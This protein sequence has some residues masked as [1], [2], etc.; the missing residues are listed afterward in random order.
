MPRATRSKSVML[1]AA[2]IACSIAWLAGCQSPR[3]PSAELDPNRAS[4]PQTELGP[5]PDKDMVA[6]VYN[7]RVADISRLA[8]PFTIVLNMPGEKPGSRRREQLEGNLQ[9]IQPDKVSLRIDKVGQTLLV[10]GAGS[11]KYW[12][13]EFGD[14]RTAYVGEIAQATYSKAERL[15]VPVHPLDIVELIG[16]VPLTGNEL[17]AWDRGFLRLTS[18]ARFGSRVLFLDPQ[19][20]EPR[21]VWLRDPRGK[22]AVWAELTRV[23]PVQVEA[24]V[25]SQARMPLRVLA[26][27]P[28]ADT[29]M[30]LSFSQPRNTGDKIRTKQFDLTSVLAAYGDP[31]RVD[32][33]ER[34]RDANTPPNVTTPT[35]VPLPV[36][37]DR[38][39]QG[40]PNR[41]ASQPSEQ[42]KQQP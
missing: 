15:G 4:T 23:G 27:V 13:I 30:E 1:W 39:A 33:D 14:T 29:D 34:W 18:R 8:S 11:G 6:A 41:E 16:I 31:A 2:G 37:T 17:M 10:M 21:A 25:R 26:R 3:G 9:L 19:T 40:A 12:W 24:N 28:D 35:R 32:I 36:V 38:D 22:V 5:L 42:K 20:Y 7:L